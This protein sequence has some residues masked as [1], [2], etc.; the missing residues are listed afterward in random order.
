[1]QSKIPKQKEREKK[2]VN[3]GWKFLSSQLD[4]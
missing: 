2:Y 1:M 4:I 3:E